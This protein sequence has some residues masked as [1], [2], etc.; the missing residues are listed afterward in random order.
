MEDGAA[1]G[2]DA[3]DGGAGGSGE[4]PAVAGDHGV[5][6]GMFGERFGDARLNAGGLPRIDHDLDRLADP[7][8]GL[9]AAGEQ[10]LVA[11]FGLH[12]KQFGGARDGEALAGGQTGDDLRHAEEGV[13]AEA[14]RVLHAGVDHVD[15]RSLDG[16]LAH[17]A[18]H[19]ERVR[20]GDDDHVEALGDAVFDHADALVGVGGGLPGDA[21]VEGLPGGFG[22]GA[23]LLP[24]G[25]VELAV[26]DKGDREGLH[27]GQTEPL[28]GGVGAG[29]GDQHRGQQRAEQRGRQTT[30]GAA[31]RHSGPRISG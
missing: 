15:D 5:D 27:G 31:A 24:D 3:I 30:Q 10:A 28:Q 20:Q 4:A 18:L 9:L 23:D 25:V 6:G 11:L 17:D 14:E 21:G 22:A 2:A 26:D 1:G 29:G 8:F 13:G 12:A 16:R 19:A 7:E